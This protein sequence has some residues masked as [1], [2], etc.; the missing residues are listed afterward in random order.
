MTRRELPSFLLLTFV[1]KD[2]VKASNEMGKLGT[3]VLGLR[4]LFHSG[5][6]RVPLWRQFQ[7]DM[8]SALGFRMLPELAALHTSRESTWL[9]PLLERNTSAPRKY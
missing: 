6:P 1:D 9:E 7:E 8:Q 3:Q 4:M 2:L 5:P